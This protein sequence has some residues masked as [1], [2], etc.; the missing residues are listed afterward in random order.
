VAYDMATPFSETITLESGQR[1][2]LAGDAS[3]QAGWSIDD[4]LLIEIQGTA[5]T[6]RFIIGTT[7]SVYYKGN[8]VEQLGTT[9][10]NFSPDDI[11]LTPHLPKGEPVKLTIS[12]LDFVGIGHVSDLYLIIR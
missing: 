9:G 5:E 8:L 12:A 11:D 6:K 4:F 1:C 2:F 3:G 10:S 7:A